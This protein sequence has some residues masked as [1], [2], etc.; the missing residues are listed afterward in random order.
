M[1]KTITQYEFINIISR[2]PYAPFSRAGAG[3]LF[4]ILTEYE[5]EG[6]MEMDPVAFRCYYAEYES[7][8]EAMR[9]FQ[10]EDM[11]IAEDTG[12][13][14]NGHGMDLV[15]IAEEEERMALEWL[16]ERTIVCPFDGGIIIQNF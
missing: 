10:P 15:E 12:V 16:Q 13:D 3:A 5:T 6:E 9:E 4:D 11:P 8:T 14:E 7:A 2:D 1:K